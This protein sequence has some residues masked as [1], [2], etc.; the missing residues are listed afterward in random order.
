MHDLLIL[1]AEAPDCSSASATFQTDMGIVYAVVTK[2]A[3]SKSKNAK[4]VDKS[5][6]KVKRIERLADSALMKR[7]RALSDDAEVARLHSNVQQIAGKAAQLL[8][9]VV[10]HMPLYTLHNE[11]HILNVIGW[12]ESLL[13]DGI[14]KLSE[15]ECGLCILAAYTHDL[16]MTLSK[17]ESDKLPENP[18]YVRFRHSF[19]E[20]RQLIEQ[21]REQKHYYRAQLIENHLWTEYVRSTHAND[22]AQRLR[23]RLK[24][25]ASDDELTYRGFNFRTQLEL[26]AISHNQPVDWLRD[27][28]KDK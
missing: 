16:G 9:T 27:E 8:T 23:T 6:L 5:N 17:D 12:M 22:R 28:F 14:Q 20:E 18:D 4:S 25:I 15:L 19:L 10:K 7:L 26:V 21:L 2:M 1:N 13:G 11:R 3:N 24:E